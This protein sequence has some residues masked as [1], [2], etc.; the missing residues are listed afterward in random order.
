M[1]LLGLSRPMHSVPVPINV[2]CYSNSD[3]IVRLSEVT[4]WAKSDIAPLHSI[5][6]SVSASNVGGISKCS[7]LA[8]FRLIRL[9]SR[10]ALATCEFLPGTP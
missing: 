1:S 9:R 7:A 8:V 4:R 6:S 5:T 3:I 10:E 2:R